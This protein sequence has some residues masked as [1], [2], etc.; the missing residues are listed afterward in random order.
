[1][2]VFSNNSSIENITSITKLIISGG[3]ESEVIVK[4]TI[5]LFDMIFKLN[6][7]SIVLFEYSELELINAGDIFI[8]V[9]VSCERGK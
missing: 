9:L 3:N 2:Y 1:L 6:S 8:V 7:T 4:W 5:N